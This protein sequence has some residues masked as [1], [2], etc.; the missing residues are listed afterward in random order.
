MTSKMA[1]KHISTALGSY[2]GDCGS[3]SRGEEEVQEVRAERDTAKALGFSS[4]QWTYVIIY[5]P[6]TKRFGL[7]VLESALV[8]IIR[9]LSKNYGYCDMG[10]GAFASLFCVTVPTISSA[11]D[12][13]E[14]I[15]LIQKSSTK[16]IWR[17]N[18]LKVSAEVNG[19]IDE[20]RA[21]IELQ[22]NT[23]QRDK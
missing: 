8:S 7:S 4:E 11:L 13:L 5:H 22:K 6:I 10:Q 2:G 19:L 17:T 21:Q 20:I 23:P 14:Q 9:T 12:R 15:G 1:I 16:S 3:P 18:K